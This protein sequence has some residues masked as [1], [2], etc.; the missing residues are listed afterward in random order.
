MARR[1]TLTSDLYRA[2][3]IS[4]NLSAVV[5]GKPSRVAR[6]SKNLVVGRTLGRTGFWRSLWR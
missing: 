6:R 4:N 3:R 1:R 2:A 5:S